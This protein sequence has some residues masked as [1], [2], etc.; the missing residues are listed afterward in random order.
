M[1]NN[2]RGI[3]KGLCAFAKKC[4]G[5]K[6]TDSALITFLITG[7]VSVSS[8]LFSAE[9][10]GNIE[11]QKQILST[12]IKDFNVLIKEARKE[13]NKLLKNTNLELVKLMEQGDHVV[14]APWSSWQFGANY[15]Y[16]KW[17]GTYKGKGDKAEKYSYEGIF[18]RSL[19]SFERVVSP[20]SE[21]YDQLEF[22]TNKYSALTSSRR[23][24]ASGYGLTGV[25]RKQEPLVSI[26]INAAVKPKTIQKNPLTLSIPGINAPNVPIPTINPSTPINLELPE[27]NTPSKVVVIAKPNAEPFTGYYFDGTWSHREL[28]DN[29]SIY[30]GIDPTSLI[31]NINNTNPTPAAMT[32]SYNGRQL[33]GTRIINEDNRY[34]N[35]YY[36]NSQTNATKIEN[37]T[38][39]LRG[40]YPTDS[41]DDSNT[42]AHLGLSDNGQ[43]AYNDGHGHG[44]PDE[45][46]VGVHALNNLKFKNLVFN[47]YGRAGAMTNETWRHG[48]LDLDNVTVN[49]Y[50]SDNMEIGRAHV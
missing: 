26:E 12:D 19:N 38:F 6:Y 30:S 7:A 48:I 46:V 20:L 18:A 39:Y 32:G 33:E 35:A 10:D 45:G 42:R 17:N 34:T 31:G 44:I 23:G 5:F 41:Y 2:L 40:H 43:R 13:N 28:R 25:E 47:L 49:M 29:I 37:N 16:S 27:P 15:M 50:N 3:R 14:K 21:K 22:S 24:L 1:T 8:N 11:N 9:K 36:I 4:K